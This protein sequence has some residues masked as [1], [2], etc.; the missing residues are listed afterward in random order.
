LRNYARCL[1]LDA[2]AAVAQFASSRSETEPSPAAVPD[3]QR[4]FAQRPETRVVEREDAP[5]RGL[6]FGA[7]AG[8]AVA[9]ALVLFAGYQ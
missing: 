1:G 4:T 8:M 6:S 7:V 9:L 2:D 5:R 3:P